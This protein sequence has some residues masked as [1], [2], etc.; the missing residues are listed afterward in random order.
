MSTSNQDSIAV[1][2]QSRPPASRRLPPSQRAAAVGLVA[3]MAIGSI[4]MWL[5]APLGSIWLAA[6]LQDGNQPQLLPIVLILVACP[7]L[8]VAIASVLHR[9]DR[10]LTEITGIGRETRKVPA[11]WH[12]SM[13]EERTGG[14]RTHV[15]DV[16][17]LVSA[18][19]AWIAVGLWFFLLADAKLP[20]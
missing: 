16:V 15:L 4:V 9:L 5:G 10:A 3:L 7:L 17:M 19:L 13:R 6:H 20:T 12:R 2:L 18:G 11:P 14:R 8:M 1:S